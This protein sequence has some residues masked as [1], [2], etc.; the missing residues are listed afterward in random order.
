MGGYLYFVNVHGIRGWFVSF[1]VPFESVSFFKLLKLTSDDK[2]DLC[3][4][5]KF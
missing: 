3:S 5:L 4:L 2:G 1:C